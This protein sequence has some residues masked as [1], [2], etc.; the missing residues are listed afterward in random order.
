MDAY[1]NAW[2]DL[3]LASHRAYTRGVQTG[4][5][6]NASA[7]ISGQD[8]MMMVKN[9]GGSFADCTAEGKGWMPMSF[10]GE[11]DAA[12]GKPTREW[13]LH[14]ALLKE[15]EHVGAVMHCHSPWA[16]SYAEDNDTL[17]LVTWHSQ[18]K[19]VVEIPVFDVKAAV[20]PQED[21][22][23][24]IAAFKK[25]T[26]LAGIILRGHGIVA[27][28]KTAVDAEHALELIE[29]TAQIATLTKLLRK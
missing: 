24:I 5:G 1:K 20:V 22:A 9:S 21:L 10:D 14:G 4:S 15:L 13:L 25:D 29:E 7:R 2:A 12:N 16:I 3:T 18:L 23:P 17:P 19:M 8:S 6:G 26:V 27:V 28:G 11:F